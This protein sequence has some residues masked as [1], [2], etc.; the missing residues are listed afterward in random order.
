MTYE[1]FVELIQQAER[2]NRYDLFFWMFKKYPNHRASYN[3]W[4]AQ[5][6]E[7]TKASE[8]QFDT[9]AGWERLC[10]KMRERGL[11]KF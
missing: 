5:I 11:M 7:E 6:E 8:V 2:E 3:R 4:I 9:K 1:K 10:E